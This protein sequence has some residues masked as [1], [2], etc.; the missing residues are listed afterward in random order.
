MWLVRWQEVMGA[1]DSEISLLQ[2]WEVLVR[3]AALTVFA[4]HKPRI[5]ERGKAVDGTTRGYVDGPYKEL[6]RKKGR[7]V[8]FVNLEFTGQ[9]KKDYQVTTSGTV[10]YAFTNQINSDKADGEEEYRGKIIFDLTRAEDEMYVRIMDK[11]ISKQLS[12]I[13]KQL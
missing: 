3:K 13:S 10:G 5:F 4:E 8:N 2:N 9:M 11:L 1:F 7:E 6:R 12:L